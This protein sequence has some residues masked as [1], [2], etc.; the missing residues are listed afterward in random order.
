MLVSITHLFTETTF[1]VSR[2]EVFN[3]NIMVVPL[4]L[5]HLSKLSSFMELLH[6]RKIN[7]RDNCT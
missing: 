2:N 1:L 3:S 4:G 7:N 6:S 5:L